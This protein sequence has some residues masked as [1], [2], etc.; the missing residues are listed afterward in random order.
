MATPAYQPP[1]RRAI[2]QVVL[3]LLMWCDAFR[4]SPPSSTGGPNARSWRVDLLPMIE[5]SSLRKSYDDTQPWQS[6]TNQQVLSQRPWAFEPSVLPVEAYAYLGVPAPGETTRFVAI[7][8]TVTAWQPGQGFDLRRIEDGTANTIVLI[9]A[10]ELGVLWTEPRDAT[11]SEAIALLGSPVHRYSDHFFYVREW[12]SEFRYVA[13]ADGHVEEVAMLNPQAATAYLTSA[14]NDA[15]LVTAAYN[16]PWRR[17]T[18]NFAITHVKWDR[19]IMAATAVVI[20]IGILAFRVRRR[21]AQYAEA[22][23][24]RRHPDLF[25]QS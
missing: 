23:V 25:S 5:E 15:H 6:P 17:P 7:V 3:G 10:P 13:F 20:G 1:N 24:R 9:E 21:R 14:G 18:A 11:L 22:W 8:D 19:V 2:K 16:G 12:V 4:W